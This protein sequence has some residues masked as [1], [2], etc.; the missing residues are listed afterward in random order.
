MTISVII[1]LAIVN[2]FAKKQHEFSNYSRIAYSGIFQ[3][4]SPS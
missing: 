2:S 3:K 4:A 1:I